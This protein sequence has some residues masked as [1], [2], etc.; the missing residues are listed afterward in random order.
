VPSRRHDGQVTPPDSFLELP[1]PQRFAVLGGLGLGALGALVGLVVGWA[2][3]PPT[4]W[5]AALE[6]GVPSVLLGAVVGLAVGSV[7]LRMLRGR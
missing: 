6:V 5:A 1:L 4:A 2:V 3:H 7:R